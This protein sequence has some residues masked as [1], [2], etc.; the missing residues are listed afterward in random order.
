MP[1]DAWPNGHPQT[2]Q[3]AIQQGKHLA[4]NLIRLVKGEPLETF[5]FRD[6]G[7]MATVDRGL[8]VVDLPKAKFQGY[9]AWLTWLFVQLVN[10]IG[11]K[12][13]LLILINRMWGYFS[14]DQSLRLIIKPK[15]PLANLEAAR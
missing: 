4:E 13:R 6:L 12:N 1:E 5:R 10:I 14:Y 7:T 9:F 8:A 2:A 11:V 3:P 15:L